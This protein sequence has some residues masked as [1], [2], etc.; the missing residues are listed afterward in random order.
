MEALPGIV[1][2]NLVPQPQDDDSATY[3]HKINK[4]EG[5]IDWRASSVEIQR[6]IRAFNPWPVAYTRQGA[7]V[8]RIWE[9]RLVEGSG[10]N[11]PGAVINASRDGIDVATGD[12]ILRLLTLQP[13]GKRAMSA[14]EFLNAR[15]LD[16][17][18]LGAE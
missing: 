2:G 9:A 13:P 14:A 18:V 6:K 11:Q 4:S 12:G 16:G 7:D 10:G 3:A 5:E 15:S 1:D 17:V 8:L